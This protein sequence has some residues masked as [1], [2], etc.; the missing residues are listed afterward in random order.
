MT[1]AAILVV[2]VIS[3]WLL[4]IS[5]II[6]GN[7]DPSKRE[8]TFRTY[9]NNSSD[10]ILCLTGNPLAVQDKVRSRIQCT[11]RCLENPRC[12]GVNWKEP[13]TCELYTSI[14]GTFDTVTGCTYMSEQFTFEYSNILTKCEC[15]C[16]CMLNVN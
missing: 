10:E 9:K 16:E 11:K 15:K 13:S 1:V 3:V 8:T 5:T 4:V 2:T 12:S 6:T 14:E 7:G